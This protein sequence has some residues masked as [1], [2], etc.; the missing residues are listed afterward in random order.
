[1]THQEI[2][3]EVRML[4]QTKDQ[5]EAFVRGYQEGLRQIQFKIDAHKKVLEREQA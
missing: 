1:M 4:E 5:L 2:R 3:E